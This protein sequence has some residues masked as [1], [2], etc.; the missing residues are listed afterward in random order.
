MAVKGAENE[1]IGDLGD[2]EEAAKQ[3]D[4]A[5]VAVERTRLEDLARELEAEVAEGR[6]NQRELKEEAA[7]SA[8]QSKS[9]IERLQQLLATSREGH[10]DSIKELR[11][12]RKFIL[13]DEEQ[14][15]R[16]AEE[17][18]AKIDAAQEGLAQEVKDRKSKGIKQDKIFEAM[19]TQLLC[20]VEGRRVTESRVNELKLAMAASEKEYQL[21][22]GQLKMQLSSS[23]GKAVDEPPVTSEQVAELKGMLDKCVEERNV[24]QNDLECKEVQWQSLIDEMQRD[25]ASEMACLRTQHQREITDLRSKLQNEISDLQAEVAGLQDL[26]V[27]AQDT[28]W[29]IVSSFPGALAFRCGLSDD[30]TIREATAAA[31][32]VWGAKA[33]EG[34]S[35]SELSGKDGMESCLQEALREAVGGGEAPRQCIKCHELGPGQFDFDFPC[36]SPCSREA[37]ANVVVVSYPPSSRDDGGPGLLVV[38]HRGLTEPPADGGASPPALG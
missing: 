3:A 24:L 28:S 8:A 2:F 25:Q 21:I 6:A 9:S 16:K 10:S 15:A 30:C 13:D 5:V 31:R 38:L 4:A 27:Q 29:K 18:Q 14:H 1:D 37:I 7:D 17:M 32:D 12:L 19:Q 35:L 20:A 34:T 36:A 11:D 22:I 23:G 33:A 26:C